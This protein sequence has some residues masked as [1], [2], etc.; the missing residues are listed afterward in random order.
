MKNDFPCSI[1]VKRPAAAAPALPA[2]SVQ[3]A[4]RPTSTAPATRLPV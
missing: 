1:R 4:A 3:P 2:A